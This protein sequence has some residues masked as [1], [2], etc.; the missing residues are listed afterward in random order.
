MICKPRF[1][2][3]ALV[4]NI[5][6]FLLSGIVSIIQAQGDAWTMKS[7]IPTPRVY[8]STNVIDGIIYAI[9]GNGGKTKVEAYDPL[10]DSWT[11][12]TDMPTERVVFTTSAVNGKIYAFGG[13]S[14]L[15][16]PDIAIVEMYDPAT[17]T[18]TRVADMPTP[19]R[20]LTSCTVDGKIYVIGG[21]SHTLGVL[22]IVE[23]YDP[24]T[25]TWTTKA[26]MPT[27]RNNLSTCV[28]N[29]KIYALGGVIGTSEVLPSFEVYDPVT[30]AWSRKA[31]MPTAKGSFS[32]SVVKN[33]I[34]VIGGST[35]PFPHS[36][37]LST[38]EE[39]DLVT[40]TWVK[41]VDMPTARWGIATSVVDGKIYAIGGSITP[42]PAT[43]TAAVEEYE[44]PSEAPYICYLNHVIDDSSDNNNGRADAGEIVNLMLTLRNI[45]FDVSNVSVTLST[46]D[47]VVQISQNIANYGD[48]ARAQRV[49]NQENPFTFSVSS[50]SVAHLSTFYMDITGE[51]GYAQ[52]DS[53]NLIIGTSSILLVDDDGGA[54][55]EVYYIKL[56]NDKQIYPYDWDVAVQGMPIHTMEAYQTIIWFTGDDR[57]NT[58]TSDEQAVIH[59]ILENGQ[60]LL[61]T[62]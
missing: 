28:V 1:K 21:L 43:I 31:D 52:T 4:F 42:Y 5:T 45:R 13:Q 51:G 36:I 57:E 19:R 61:I 27:A 11:T 29:G 22:D 48:I 15:G 60:R 59:S 17:N 41:R 16:S 24:A 32:T 18:W 39:Y 8:L 20:D 6:I 34:Y 49:D 23:E 40:D 44:P 53:F 35:T 62:G 47:P 56:L 25:D 55:Y 12:K 58:L 30:D 54:N 10:T 26:N 50:P 46:Y 9:G 2:N 14:N 33:M 7:D 38:T 37:M 3:V